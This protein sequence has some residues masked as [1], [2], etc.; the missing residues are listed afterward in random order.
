MP[1]AIK[2]DVEGFEGRVL[3]GATK[4][5]AS[6]Q[7]RSVVVEIT[8]QLTRYGD[9]GQGITST[10]LTAGFEGPFWYEPSTR[11]LLP[12]GAPR[13]TKYNHIFVRNKSDTEA[14]LQSAPKYKIHGTEV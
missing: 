11:R 4:T 14:R 7:L 6:N 1:S 3:R 8:D 12:V 2:I 10:L 5:L 13:S 9:T